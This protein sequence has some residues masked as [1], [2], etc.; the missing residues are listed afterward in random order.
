MLGQLAGM[1]S[2][3]CRHNARHTGQESARQC[4][5]KANDFSARF[6]RNGATPETTK[7]AAE[8]NRSSNVQR[9]TNCLRTVGNPYLGTSG[10]LV[11]R[12]EPTA[13]RR[14]TPECNSTRCFAD[15]RFEP[16]ESAPGNS[17]SRKLTYYLRLF[18]IRP[19]HALGR[20]ASTPSR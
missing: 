6:N 20:S 4:P 17:P 11:I 9:F 2:S 13:L 5:S 19:V 3:V 14:A 8:R 16:A 10:L 18:C 7:Q 15:C 1:L 12:E